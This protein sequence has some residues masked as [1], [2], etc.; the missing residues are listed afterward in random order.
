[1]VTTEEEFEGST[2]QRCPHDKQ[3]PYV[4]INSNLIDDETISPLCRWLLIY[5]LKNKDG[6]KICPQQVINHAKEF[7]GRDKVLALFD[8][9]IEKGYMYRVVKKNG[10]LNNGY[11]YFVSETPKFKKSFRDPEKPETEKLKKSFRQPAPQGSEAQAPEDTE[12]NYNEYIN[13]IFPREINKEEGGELEARAPA[14]ATPPPPSSSAAPLKKTKSDTPLKSPSKVLPKVPPKDD[15]ISFGEHVKLRPEEYETLCGDLGK[16]VIDLY[17]TK[18]NNYVPNKPG[19]PYKDYAAVIRQWIFKDQT[20]GKKIPV[21]VQ[22]KSGESKN[23]FDLNKKLCDRAE[24][25]LLPFVTTRTFFNAG[26]NEAILIS[27]EKDVE[28]RYSYDIDT[29]VL[30][31]KIIQDCERY[32]GVRAAEALMGKRQKTVGDIVGQA[33]ESLQ[34]QTCMRV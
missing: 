7:L 13:S 26:P 34:K 21:P 30:K 33:Y 19:A 14:H 12:H 11:K 32:I 27:I 1:M 24:M 8:E 22:P 6:W 17:I 2:I 20:E 10:N 25:E 15:K 3:H 29:Q 5:L 31:N 18:I 4:M 28:I 16:A 23:K 9:A